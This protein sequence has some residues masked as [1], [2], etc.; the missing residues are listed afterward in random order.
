MLTLNRE[1]NEEKDVKIKTDDDLYYYIDMAIYMADII[2]NYMQDKSTQDHN[3]YND[4]EIINYQDTLNK[5]SV[6]HKDI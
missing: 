3:Y 4:Q 1:G 5:Y 2:D 6:S